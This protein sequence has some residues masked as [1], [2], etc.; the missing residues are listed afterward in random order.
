M[1]IRSGGLWNLPPAYHESNYH[2]QAEYRPYMQFGAWCQMWSTSRGQGRVLAFADSTLF[3]N[4]CVFQPGKAELLRGMLD[5]LNH[6]S[7]LD[8]RAARLG[9]VLPLGLFAAL[10]LAWGVWMGRTLGGGWMLMVALGYAGWAAAAGV[11]IADHRCGLP[12]PEVQRAEP[13]VVIDR[14][15]SQVPLFTGAFADDKEGLGYGLFE[16]WIPRIGN[17]TSRRT[18]S[19]AFTGEAIV[20]VCPTRSVTAEYQ[21]RLLEFVARGGRVLVLDSPDVPGLDGQQHLVAVRLGIHVRGSR[22]KRW[23]LDV[24]GRT[25]GPSDRVAGVLPD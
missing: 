22:A 8:R 4:F 5:W 20:I 17:W 9:L 13:H 25:V 10:L 24:E 7:V 19:E 14:T 18:G 21:Q 12:V 15:V 2:P 3:S 6:R 1:V 16:Q 11:T 23:K